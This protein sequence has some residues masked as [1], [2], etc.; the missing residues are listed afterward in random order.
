ML[1]TVVPQVEKLYEDLGRPLPT[2]TQIMVDTANF[3]TQFWWIVLLV[4][5]IGGYFFVQYLH[6]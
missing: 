1:F 2:L 3:V 6:T 5:I 4:L